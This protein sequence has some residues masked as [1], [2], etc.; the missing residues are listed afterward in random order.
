MASGD[1][2]LSDVLQD[3]VG[4]VQEMVRSE[5]SLAKT[6]I[7][8]EAVKARSSGLLLGGGAITGAFAMLF[9]LLTILSAL[10]MVMPVW[11]A[12]LIVGVLL[13]GVASAMLAA[14]I[15]RFREIRSVPER[16]V[17]VA[18]IR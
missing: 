6:E 1:R 9:L 18:G 12:A 7:R 14:G 2:S 17:L 11:S 8:A 10:A 16:T 4:N 15:K 3:I 5:I 13:A